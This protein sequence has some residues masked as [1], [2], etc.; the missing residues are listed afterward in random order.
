M[1]HRVSAI[2]LLSVSA[3]TAASSPAFAVDQLVYASL[4]QPCRLL[5][6]RSPGPGALTAA[7]GTYI[8]GSSNADIESPGQNGN[9]AGCAIPAGVSAISVNF[10]MFDATASGNILTW[11]SGATQPTAGTA[12]YNPSVINPMAGQVDFNSG[13]AT[14][15]VGASDQRFNLSVANGQIDMTINVVGYWTAVSSLSTSSGAHAVGLG[16]N[17]QASGDYSFTAG[18]QNA[19]EGARA[20]AIGYLNTAI[21][22]ESVALGAGN[23]A[24]NTNSVAIGSNNIA[25]GDGSIA[26]GNSAQTN[27]HK[28][29]FVF[30]DESVNTLNTADYQFMARA[31]GGFVFYTSTDTMTGASLAA[32]SGAW[33]ALSDRNAKDALQAIDG[34]DVLDRVVAM[35]LA[36]WHYKAQD[37]KYRHMGPMAQDFYS[38]F[39][40]G[41]SDTGIDTID[42]DG[43]ALAAIQGLNAKLERE[44]AEN[45][46]LKARVA[47]LEA[48]SADVTALKAAVKALQ[49]D[50]ASIVTTAAT[51]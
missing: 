25:N 36:T 21:G 51:P 41:E 45:A 39:H 46:A 23:Y 4:A 31:K 22:Y 49:R 18:A 34:R 38:A 42:A 11:A 37:A 43:V 19:A 5:D 15:A 27:L 16:Y 35:P 1:R 30:G 29:T 50:R 40:L 12:V 3:L 2:A 48:R 6:T 32:G 26:L 14:I 24:H 33:T 28:N 44:I 20:T 7:H 47:Q 13:F 9:A 17:S 8:L 10:N